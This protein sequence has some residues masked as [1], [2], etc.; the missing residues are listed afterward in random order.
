MRTDPEVRLIR[1]ILLLV[2][3]ALFGVVVMVGVVIWA[4]P[5]G[6]AFYEFGQTRP[7]RLPQSRSNTRYV[8]WPASRGTI[9]GER[10]IRKARMWLQPW[11]SR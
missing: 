9:D 6:L 5:N 10:R 2:G 1:A 7:R 3:I 4:R 8:S 11:E